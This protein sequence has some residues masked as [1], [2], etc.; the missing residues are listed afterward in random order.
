M[1]AFDG[2]EEEEDGGWLVGGLW[3][4]GWDARWPSCLLAL[5]YGRSRGAGWWEGG[6]A[7]LGGHRWSRISIGGS[8]SQRR[9]A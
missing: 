2:F 9:R 4:F 1:R 3:T 8:A 5:R 6:G 7:V